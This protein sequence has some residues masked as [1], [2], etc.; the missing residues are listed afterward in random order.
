MD[1]ISDYL[2]TSDLLCQLAEECSEL[3]QAALKLKMAMEGT[4]PTPKSELECWKSLEEEIADVTLAMGKIVL[5]REEL[6]MDRIVDIQND[7]NARWI[8]RLQENSIFF[9]VKSVV[10]CRNC[11]HWNEETGWCDIHSHFQGSDGEFCHPWES[12]DWKVFPVY[13][14]CADGERVAKTTRE[15]KM[16]KPRMIGQFKPFKANRRYN[17]RWQKKQ[18]RGVKSG[19]PGAEKG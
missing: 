17:W 10:R 6:A 12:N 8:H 11:K 19:K 14:F 2:S 5:S 16:G 13:Y 9:D 1:K 7:K 4:N 15:M 3:A 18:E